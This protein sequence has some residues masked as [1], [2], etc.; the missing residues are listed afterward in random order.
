MPNFADELGTHAS[1]LPW[2]LY[3]ACLM[4]EYWSETTVVLV[5]RDFLDIMQQEHETY[6]QFTDVT[7]SV[8]HLRFHQNF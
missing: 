2:D 5:Y 8:Q 1:P 7:S 6:G 3:R 4:H